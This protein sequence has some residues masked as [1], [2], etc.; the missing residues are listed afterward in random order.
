MN[1]VLFVA[2]VVDRFSVFEPNIAAMSADG[3]VRIV[4]L[5]EL[6]DSAVPIVTHDVPLLV[7]AF[8]KCEIGLPYTL[9][10]V[11]EALK[12]RSQIS[13]DQGGQRQWDVWRMGSKYFESPSDSKTIQQLLNARVPPPGTAELQRLI[14][15]AAGMLRRLWLE[16]TSELVELGEWERFAEKEVPVQQI[17][18][19]R[20]LVGVSLD[21]SVLDAYIKESENERF[22]V[23][24][25]ISS[26]LGASP[27]GLSSERLVERLTSAGTDLPE[28]ASRSDIL[29]D[30]LALSS[31]SSQT[32]STLLMYLKATRDI[33]VLR[34]LHS[35]ARRVHPT[36]HVHGTVTSRILVSEPRLQQLRKRFRGI[37][38]AEEGMELAYFD[39]SQFEPGIIAS[40]SKDA[41]LLKAYSSSDLYR[42]L[43][44]QIYGNDQSRDVAKRIF[45]AYCYGMTKTRIAGL[46][47]GA[48]A[49]HAEL[50]RFELAVTTFFA[51]FPQVEEF[52]QSCQALLATQGSVQTLM[53]NVRRRTAKGA[54]TFKEQR[55]AMNHIV[56]G[57]ASLIFKE[58]LIRLSERFGPTSII[59]PMHDA[60]LM[61]FSPDQNSRSKFE[62]EVIG[63]MANAFRHYCPNIL[64]KVLVTEFA[65]VH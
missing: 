43:S 24:R 1:E 59:L 30:W 39:Y 9:I 26:L 29:E 42:E 51:K 31:A 35:S 14:Y 8:R 7:E 61:Q 33:S 38:Q 32:A 28:D 12:F 13:R 62:D 25:K 11:L 55:W 15:A 49:N 37:L 36:F 56:Q 10:D 40:L 27:M 60:V 53:G 65:T 22:T 21:K 5:H 41:C 52:R 19:H 54:L 4:T 64:P 48:N 63:I 16:T 45:L 58:A 57:T 50:E 34:Q 47:A 46:L 44:T 3:S 6:H 23:F 17:F 20:Q 2:F 18:Y